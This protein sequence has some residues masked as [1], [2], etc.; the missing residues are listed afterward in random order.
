MHDIGLILTI[1]LGLAAALVLGYTAQRIGLSPIVGYLLAGIAVG[2]HTPGFVAD[3]KMAAQLAEIGVILLMFGVGLHFHLKDLL[4]V[5]AIAIPGA[6]GQ[7]VVATGL[8]CVVAV[9]F[10]WS[11]SAG[12]VLGIAISVASTVVLIRVL[13]DNDALSTHQG[14]IAVGWL[15]VE[16]IFTVIVLV[17]L[18]A[19]A[20][21]LSGRSETGLF[22][23]LLSALLKLIIL[24]ALVLLAGARVIPWLMAH[25]AR[26]RSRELFT[27]AVLVVALGIATGSAVFFGASMALGAFLAGM[28]VG[29]SEV[30]HQAAADALPMRDAFA[31]LF[32]VSVGMLFDPSFLI[33]QPLLVLAVLAVI[34]IGKPLAAMVIVWAFGY[35]LRVSLTIAL[36][37]AQIGEFSFI[38]ADA[39]REILPQQGRSVLVAAALLSITANPILFR[40]MGSIE[41]AV[42][43]SPRLWRFLNRRDEGL[44]SAGM[45]ATEP[46]TRVPGGRLSAVVVGYGPVG[47][48]LTRI[49]ND[50]GVHPTI[51]DLNIDTVHKLTEEGNAAIYGDAGRRD[52]LQAAGIEEATYLIVTLPDLTARFPV[53]ATAR[54]L[55]PRLKIIV[56][57]RYLGE[58]AMLEE[59]GATAVAYEEAEVAVKLAEYLLRETG[60]SK[61]QLESEAARVREELSLRP[62]RT[63]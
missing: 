26:T 56:R 53:I 14:H 5:K 62:E 59:S 18:P 8:G 17:L 27:L 40:S 16:D 9:L 51:V 63:A 22:T 13:M 45:A 6:V 54:M 37:L 15:I 48:T 7:S 24:T 39:A 19:V 44:P 29:Q 12:V 30:S 23:S 57:A 52:I 38:L 61:A 34:M 41:R 49:L 46:E 20:A 58:R 43:K 47:K 21:S 4:A 3:S 50:F 11:L 2:P 10:D 60:A 31:V 25:V 32:F 36:A 28:V 55:N 42:H 33:A 35:P 1:T